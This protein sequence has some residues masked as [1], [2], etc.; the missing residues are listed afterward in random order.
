MHYYIL[1]RLI[2]ML[3]VLFGLTIIVFTIVRLRGDPVMQFVPADESTAEIE[4]VRKA[5]GFDRPLTEQYFTFVSNAVR[6]D[7]GKSFRYKEPAL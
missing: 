6:G 5:Y 2:Q 4:V 1:R 3:P 7:F